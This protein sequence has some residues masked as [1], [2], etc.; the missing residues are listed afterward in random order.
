M[1][2]GMW[3]TMPT[4][5]ERNHFSMRLRRRILELGA[6]R[7][8]TPPVVGIRSDWLY[9]TYIKAE[10]NPGVMALQELR[11]NQVYRLER[12]RKR[13]LLARLRRVLRLRRPR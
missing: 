9:W 6:A 1:R 3:R 8:Y 5:P 12:N 10:G 7:D 11:R 4:T 2:R 13:P